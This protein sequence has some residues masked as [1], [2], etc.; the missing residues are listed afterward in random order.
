MKVYIKPKAFLVDKV[1]ISSTEYCSGNMIVT[2]QP[3]FRGTGRKKSSCMSFISYI[4]PADSES[5]SITVT[6]GLESV[7]YSETATVAKSSSIM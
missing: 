5:S 4:I 3:V 1:S 6:V 7:A 2:L